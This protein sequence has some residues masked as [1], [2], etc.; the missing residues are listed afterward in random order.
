MLADGPRR[1]PVA[2]ARDFGGRRTSS[3]EGRLAVCAATKV[4]EASLQ[5][6]QAAAAASVARLR[7]D[8]LGATVTAS[9]L[10]DHA[11]PV[12]ALE[13]FQAAEPALRWHLCVADQTVKRGTEVFFMEGAD[14]FFVPVEATVTGFYLLPVHILVVVLFQKHRHGRFMN[15]IGAGSGGARF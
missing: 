1:L 8:R 12:T 6:D 9:C 2:A 4:R 14:V 13:V 10:A 15:S 5:P 11:I 3:R 7:K